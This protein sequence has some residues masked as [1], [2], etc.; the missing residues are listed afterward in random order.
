MP[1][2]VNSNDVT[3]SLEIA[4]TI[5]RE[6]VPFPV[7]IITV[8]IATTLSPYNEIIP[9]ISDFRTLSIIDATCESQID[10]SRVASNAGLIGLSFSDGLSLQIW[11]GIYFVE[12]GEI[13]DDQRAGSKKMDEYYK[14]LFSIHSRSSMKSEEALE[15]IRWYDRLSQSISNTMM[16]KGRNIILIPLNDMREQMR[17]MEP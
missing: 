14:K 2:C 15:A 11:P 13:I 17:E 10:F 1:D 9:M 5:F 6:R 3:Q 4:R 8:D 7:E 16:F 12:T